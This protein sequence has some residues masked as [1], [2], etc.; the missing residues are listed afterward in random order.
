MKYHP[1]NL[2]ALLLVATVIFSCSRPLSDA[3]LL[4]ETPRLDGRFS[5]G[6]DNEN[7]TYSWFTDSATWSTSYFV[8]QVG[9]LYASN[10]PLL[11]TTSKEKLSAYLRGTQKHARHGTYDLV[12]TE[13]EFGGVRITERLKP[14]KKNLKDLKKQKD[15]AQ[16]YEVSFEMVN[17]GTRDKRVAFRYILDTQIKTHDEAVVEP[18]TARGLKKWFGLFRKP[19]KLSN[20]GRVFTKAN[21][22]K[23]ILVHASLARDMQN[24]IGEVRPCTK[25]FPHPD[26]LVI[27]GWRPIHQDLWS[28]RTSLR[29]DDSGISMR[30]Y[31]KTL[32]VGDTLKYR[33][34]YGLHLP[35]W[36]RRVFRKE[37]KPNEHLMLAFQGRTDYL[38]GSY[39]R[40]DKDTIEFGDSVT[41]SWNVYHND[42]FP[43]S[44]TDL[45]TNV[46]SLQLYAGELQ[47]HPLKSSR[48]WMTL[49][50]EKSKVRVLMYDTVQVEFIPGKHSGRFTLGADGQDLLFGYPF[51]LSTSHFVVSVQEERQFSS[52]AR[53]V[54]MGYGLED[55]EIRFYTNAA[56][57]IRGER[58]DEF[59]Q[60]RPSRPIRLLT[61]KLNE[62]GEGKSGNYK[63]TY[64]LEDTSLFVVQRLTAYDTFFQPVDSGQHGQYY[65][66][67]YDIGNASPK[68]KVV[69]LGLVLDTRIAGSEKGL[70]LVD[71]LE[72]WLQND[73]SLQANAFYVFNDQPDTLR[74][75]HAVLGENGATAPDQLYNTLWQ[76]IRIQPVGRAGAGLNIPN[77]RALFAQWNPVLI[78]PLSWKSYRIFLGNPMADSVE[79][80][81]HR[82]PYANIRLWYDLDA[83]TLIQGEINALQRFYQEYMAPR[84]D[85]DGKPYQPYTHL[86]VEGFTGSLG[87]DSYN[88]EL[89]RRRITHV[90]QLLA[91][92]NVP[93]RLI[94]NKIDGEYYA[95]ETPRRQRIRNNERMVWIKVYGPG[96]R[97]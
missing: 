41:V 36:G 42:C 10:Y 40:A 20:S 83:D 95:E 2:L 16:Y 90:H 71:S 29:Y 6:A 62:L 60:L 54:D 85:K 5:I 79:L 11:D 8:I 59:K 65:E 35:A 93:Q 25:D 70:M 1:M 38:V 34:H 9:E 92:L 80:K 51:E 26:D 96:I 17:T 43:D 76:H 27:G 24:L 31:P 77:D 44:L 46:D 97:K 68:A 23:K 82:E 55:G 15:Y 91:G 19:P 28:Y 64:P 84:I 33:F 58:I 47:M 21:M 50:V 3:Y 66:L 69:G 13:Y 89:A 49:Q 32:A 18:L 78:P 63:I 39:L 73:T 75:M 81:F 88:Y 94:Q 67:R 72:G 4:G 87:S 14:V 86:M 37:R 22:P 61:G 57:L 7:L 56:E 12:E 45:R 74:M 48:Y 53:Q 30:W 52:E